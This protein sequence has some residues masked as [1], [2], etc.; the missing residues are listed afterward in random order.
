MNEAMTVLES[1][2]RYRKPETIYCHLSLGSQRFYGAS[3]DKPDRFPMPGKGHDSPL[4][5][6]RFSTQQTL[7]YTCYNVKVVSAHAHTV[8]AL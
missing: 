1:I 7:T 6:T 4:S 5:A 2:P 8:C 3:R